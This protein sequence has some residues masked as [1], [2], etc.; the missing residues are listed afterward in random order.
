MGCADV[1]SPGSCGSRCAL[2]PVSAHAEKSES[3]IRIGT[4]RKQIMFSCFFLFFLVPSAGCPQYYPSSAHSHDTVS[5]TKLFIRSS[6][7]PLLKCLSL[8]KHAG[9]DRHTIDSRERTAGVCVAR[10]GGRERLMPCSYYGVLNSPRTVQRRIFETVF[11]KLQP[12]RYS[13]FACENA[14]S[15]AAAK[16]VRSTFV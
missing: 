4:T 9:L 3:K 14:M 10:L 2:V 12:V 8:P 1:Q 5:R 7:F 15:P 16:R 11:E 13:T 6:R